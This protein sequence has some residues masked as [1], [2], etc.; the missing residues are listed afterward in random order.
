MLCLTLMKAQKMTVEPLYTRKAETSTRIVFR[1]LKDPLSGTIAFHFLNNSLVLVVTTTCSNT[2]LN[3]T[4][5]CVIALLLL[6]LF[7]IITE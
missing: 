5:R 1:K 6:V 7:L 2:E 3:T 4:A